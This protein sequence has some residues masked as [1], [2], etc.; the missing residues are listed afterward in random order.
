MF[1]FSN[2]KNYMGVFISFLLAINDVGSLSLLKMV[3]TKQ[4]KSAWGT[5][6]PMIGYSIQPL[7]FLWGLQYTTMTVLNGLWDAASDVIVP[8]I[9]LGYFKEKLS[10][11]K[12]VG[13]L[14][15]LMA[16]YL[17]SGPDGE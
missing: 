6:V 16:M 7:L 3:S 11:K 17:L 14:F 12:Y 1:E 8:I 15:A 10:L 5:I 2:L 4:I 9:G 13:L